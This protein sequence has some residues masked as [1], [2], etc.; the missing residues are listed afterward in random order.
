M[1]ELH[2]SAGSRDRR[3][4]YWRAR[5][6]AR[7][8]IAMAHH[9]EYAEVLRSLPRERGRA[10]YSSAKETAKRRIARLYPDEFAVLVAAARAEIEARG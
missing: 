7:H 3:R 2:H 5:Q 4:A 10:A 9:D 6:R 1:A 8:A